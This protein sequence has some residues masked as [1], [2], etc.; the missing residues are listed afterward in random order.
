M[1][2][3]T[4]LEKYREN[5]RLEAKKSLGGL[6]H[7]I[8]ETYS[9]FANS[10]G[11][12]ILLGVVEG[13]DKS[14]S[15]VPLPDPD[16]LAADFWNTLSLPGTVSVNLLDDR[17]VQVVESGGNRI[18]VI[19]VPRADRHHRPVYVGP[20]PF[21][22]TYR[23]SGEGDYRCTREEVLSMLRDQADVSL[24]S[25]L[26]TKLT[27]EALDMDTIRR[28][29]TA[30]GSEEPEADLLR[31]TGTLRLD[32]PTAAGLLMFGREPAIRR[33]FPAYSLRYQDEGCTLRSDAGDWSGNLCDFYLRVCERL[34]RS[35]PSEPLRSAVREAVVNA[36][37][38]ADYRNRRGLVIHR[39]ARQIRIANPGAFRSDTSRA[40]AGVGSDPRNA[41]L[42]RMFRL[43]G[44][45]GGLSAIRDVWQA[46]GWQAPQILESFGPD[47][48]LLTLP[49]RPPAAEK[50]PAA[51]RRQQQIV[52]FLTDEVT[53]TPDQIARAIGLS[54][55]RARVYLRQLLQR[56]ALVRTAGG[57]TLPS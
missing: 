22:G 32:H 3:W 41:L 6:P 9:A 53:A 46:Q 57:Y 39:T 50:L 38:H 19:E 24:D 33:E 37:V 16:Q 43:L 10:Y 30:I 35:L 7:S 36:L 20:D 17:S 25:R 18:V 4:H 26:L 21:S 2:D 40:F 48:T 11:G 29:R 47:R 14:F 31:R 45:G 34:D 28:F 5:N 49:L 27:E 54:S 44:G 42:S 1:L 8:W 12:L 56:G 15:T 55:S 23:R 13:P 52:D 51:E